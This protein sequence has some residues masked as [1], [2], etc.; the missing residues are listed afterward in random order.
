MRRLLRA[1]IAGVVAMCALGAVSSAAD[2]ATTASHGCGSGYFCIYAS[3]ATW[4]A[5]QPSY[6]FYH[7]GAH[8]IYNQYGGHWVYNHQTGGAWVI[9]CAGANGTGSAIDGIETPN[10]SHLWDLTPV[11]SVVLEPHTYNGTG[12]VASACATDAHNAG[13]YP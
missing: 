13:W 10:Y 4:N 3:D 9:F 12:M 5:G 6:A 1:V 7:Y 2:A 8:N 11:N